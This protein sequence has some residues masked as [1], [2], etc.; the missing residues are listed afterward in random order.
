MKADPNDATSGIVENPFDKGIIN[1]VREMLYRN[2]GWAILRPNEP[3][4]ISPLNYF[5]EQ[6]IEKAEFEYRSEVDTTN[7]SSDNG[8]DPQSMIDISG[9]TDSTSTREINPMDIGKYFQK[10][11]RNYRVKYFYPDEQIIYS[12]LQ[13]SCPM[14][15]KV[16]KKLEK[17]CSK[18]GLSMSSDEL[19]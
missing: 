3:D 1:N 11:C 19:A 5:N 9:N 17:K 7:N 6:Q 14:Q 10:L 18:M 13:I 2:I 8:R 12:I 15:R 16:L 4:E